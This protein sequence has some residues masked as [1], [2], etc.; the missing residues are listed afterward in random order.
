MPLV[1]QAEYA[2]HRHISRE[3]V[4]KRT[5]TAGGPIPVHGPRRLIDVAEADALRTVTKAVHADAGA[6]S[7]AYYE[8]KTARMV[9]DAKRAALEF[10]VREGQ[11]VDRQ[12][13]ERAAEQLL[14][15][16]RDSLLRW[17]ARVAAGGG[18]A[19]AVPAC[20]GRVRLIG[21]VEALREGAVEW[22]DEG[23]TFRI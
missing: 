19:A 9:V 23:Q 6:S 17:P 10:R 18:H 15:R 7:A 3:A 11:L 2:R 4:G 12:A 8:A 20:P 5:A 16:V 13:A 1:T 22:R 21:G 14:R